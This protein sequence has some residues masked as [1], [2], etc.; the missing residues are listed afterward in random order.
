MILRPR[1]VHTCWGPDVFMLHSLDDRERNPSRV[2]L[3]LFLSEGAL[4]LVAWGGD[5]PNRVKTVPCYHQVSVVQ[6]HFGQGEMVSQ[7]AVT[8][9]VLEG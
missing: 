1:L 6:Q 3:F 9:L 2:F 4:H 7:L 8:D 5:K